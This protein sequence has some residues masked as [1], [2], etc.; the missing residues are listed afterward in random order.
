MRNNFLSKLK[1]YVKVINNTKESLAN[2]DNSTNIYKMNKD[3]YNKY[4]TENITKTYKKANKNKVNRI[5]SE[6]K[7]IAEKI[8]LD[9]RIQQLQETEAFISVKDHKEGFPNSP[10][11][12]LI[13]PSKSEIGKISKYILDKIN[14]SLLNN[15]KVNQWKNTSDAISWFKNINSNKQSSFVNFDVENFYPST[16][17]K[18]LIDA[19]NFEKSSIN[20]TE[21]D[22]PIIMQSKKTLLFQKS[23][24]WVKK[25]GNED[26]DVPK[27]CYNGA[28]VCE[29]V[30]SFI[31][32][33]L[34][35]I[36]NKSN[37]GFYRDDGL[38]IF[39]NV[40]KPEIERK[41]KAIVEVF[42][43]CGLSITIQCNLKI[44]DFLGVT[45]DLE[46]NVYKPFRKENNKPI[47]INKHSNH[48]PSILQQLP[49]SIKKRISETS[50]N[51]DIFDKSIKPYKN[52][53]KESGFSDTLNYIAP[54]TNRDPKK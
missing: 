6:A 30:G 7:K 29:L 26:F 41:K 53:L 49:K 52:A 22:L 13:N 32:N 38:G 33:K 12:T 50:S 34:T 46:N 45:F 23:E 35:P 8:K 10:S 21:Q 2:T 14:K 28:E 25:T 40:S 31:L 39:Q 19:I 15:T 1:E 3:V 43:G 17:E 18:L 11:F 5:N 51:K 24:S 4:L 47:Y 27:G 20:I 37:M 36:I 42:K 54:K 44:V 48:P 16:S 9:D